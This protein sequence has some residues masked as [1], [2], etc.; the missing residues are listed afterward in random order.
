MNAG[1]NTISTNSQPI[2][3]STQI[4]QT[5]TKGT[6]LTEKRNLGTKE[7]RLQSDSYQTSDKGITGAFPERILGRD[8]CFFIKPRYVFQ[9]GADTLRFDINRQGALTP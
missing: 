3:C 2:K 8:R 6:Q 9:R 1:I 7:S 4:E 5:R